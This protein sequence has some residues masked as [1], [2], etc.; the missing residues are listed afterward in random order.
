V[1]HDVGPLAGEFERDAL[2]NPRPGAG[3]EHSFVS[4]PSGFNHGFP[5]VRDL[6]A[7]SLGSE[8]ALHAEVSIVIITATPTFC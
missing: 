3:D 5:F 6:L 2:S 1:N 4:H 8:F 7:A